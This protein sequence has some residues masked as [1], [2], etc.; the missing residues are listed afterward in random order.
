MNSENVKPNDPEQAKNWQ[1]L[2]QKSCQQT[3]VPPQLK[4]QIIRNLQ[5]KKTAQKN[6][7]PWLALAASFVVAVLMLQVYQSKPMFQQ[8]QPQVELIELELLQEITETQNKPEFIV[9]IEKRLANY[10]QQQIAINNAFKNQMLRLQS[11]Y[12]N[13]PDALLYARY[14][15]LKQEN[16]QLILSL[17]DNKTLQVL[18]SSG[19]NKKAQKSW[20]NRL[21][22]YQTVQIL[23]SD[24]GQIAG[25]LPSQIKNCS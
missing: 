8:I 12:L 14:A 5:K 3:S 15:V 10:Q 22:P 1:T 16:E 6:I 25:I 23:L 17:C 7:K 2:Y 11:S 4:Q 21:Q 18:K 19:L 20:L 13:K 24:A 9:N